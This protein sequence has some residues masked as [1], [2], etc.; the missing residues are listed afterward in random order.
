MIHTKLLIRRLAYVPWLLAFGLVLGWAGEAQAQ[1]RITLSVDK[2]KVREDGGA[3]EIVVTAKRATKDPDNPTY[4]GLTLDTHALDQLNNRFY[5]DLP[6]IIIPKD[7]AEAKLTITLTPIQ[8]MDVEGNL[9]ITIGS[10]LPDSVAAVAAGV[11]GYTITN[12]DAMITLVDDDGVSEGIELTYGGAMINQDGD[13]TAVTVTATLDGA[14]LK[15]NL[16]FA[17]LF[18]PA[19]PADRAVRDRDWKGDGVPIVIRKGDPS[20]TAKI[21]I[22]PLN[23]EAGGIELTTTDMDAAAT[24]VQVYGI[25]AYVITATDGDYK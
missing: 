12:T 2:M 5:M 22:T 21:E 17:L 8:N 11:N 4:V 25:V 13:R 24:G 9:V 18:D 3:T 14:T 6:T 16:R 1:T 15:E 7:T 20:G 10:T 23:K 19:N